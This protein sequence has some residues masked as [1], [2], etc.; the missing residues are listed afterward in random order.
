M[1]IS[2]LELHRPSNSL[3]FVIRSVE[4]KKVE[5]FCGALE[6]EEKKISIDLLQGR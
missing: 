1:G 2:V 5:I 6:Y 4:S 3:S